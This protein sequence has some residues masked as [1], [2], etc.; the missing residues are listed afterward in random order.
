MAFGSP[1]RNTASGAFS[2]VDINRS[3]LVRYTFPHSCRSL[4]SANVIV[5]RVNAP[6]Q[7]SSTPPH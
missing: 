3:S 5:V 7:D 1:G 4:S 6:L 2:V